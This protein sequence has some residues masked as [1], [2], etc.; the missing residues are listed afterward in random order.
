M[1]SKDKDP[2]FRN[3]KFLDFLKRVKTG[4]YELKDNK[5][6]QHPEKANAAEL[7]RIESLTN[8]FNE[9]MKQDDQQ[10]Q[11]FNN[12]EGNFMEARNKVDIEDA[13]LEAMETQWKES[14]ETVEKDIAKE[15]EERA[16]RIQKM[17]SKLANEYDPENPELMAELENQ[18]MKELNNWEENKL[19][20]HWQTAQDLEETQYIRKK[21][22]PSPN[23]RYA[24]H[25]NPHR[26]FIKCQSSGD[27]AG[28]IL[29]LE[30]H[31]QK[32]PQD[33]RALRMLGTLLQ[34]N[35]NDSLSVSL[36]LDA[37]K[38][39]PNC[40]ETLFQLGVS[41]TNILDE[42]TSMMYLQDWLNKEFPQIGLGELVSPQRLALD[43]YTSEEILA[44]N[45]LLIEK[46]ETAKNT[47]PI[48]PKLLMATGVLYFIGRDYKFAVEN[49]QASLHIDDQDYSGWNKFGAALAHLGQKELARDAYSKAL[50]L[51][52]NYMR[53]WVNLGLN[54]SNEVIKIFIKGRL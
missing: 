33:H 27:I 15:A 22:Q 47:G 31:L 18:F 8:E 7:E 53:T 48:T 16:E 21:Y 1:M 37:L 51:K 52:P 2:R 9:A 11:V 42:I 32:H 13:K 50:D 44:I 30:A 14:T 19:A 29:A 25:P 28:S 3:S 23:N 17:W 41:C 10:Q 46:F 43:D 34:E 6:I 26:Q 38:T 40:S 20:D 5:L 4:E 49:F 39:D 45:R 54:Y 35:D 12:F 24:N 36:L